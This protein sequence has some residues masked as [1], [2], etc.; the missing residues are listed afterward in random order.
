MSAQH[1]KKLILPP[2]ICFGL[3]LVV[4]A[5]GFGSAA[6]KHNGFALI[7]FM[8]F[9]VPFSLVACIVGVTLYTKAYKSLPSGHWGKVLLGIFLFWWHWL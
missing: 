6:I 7:G 2:L 8:Q 1:D 4:G 9:Y 5:L 3:V